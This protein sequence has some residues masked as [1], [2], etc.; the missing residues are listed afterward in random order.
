MP[1][2]LNPLR[3]KRGVAQATPPRY[4]SWIKGLKFVAIYERS[5]TRG[6]GIISFAYEKYLPPRAR[7]L[8]PRWMKTIIHL[9]WKRS[10]PKK[11]YLISSIDRCSV[12]QDRFADAKNYWDIIGP[13]DEVIL[14]D[15]NF[16]H[17]GLLVEVMRRGHHFKL[18]DATMV[19]D[20]LEERYPGAEK[21]LNMADFLLDCYHEGLWAPRADPPHKKGI[22][23]ALPAPKSTLPTTV[24]K[25]T[26]PS[27][28]ARASSHGLLLSVA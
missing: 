23:L 10:R 4:V 28:R 17:A 9:L 25:Q 14:V 7:T 20:R 12:T 27:A 5:D 18:L 11:R 13:D 22:Y 26:I 6:N 15:D 19:Q 21:R 2:P 8:V 3:T 16:T 1:P 24:G